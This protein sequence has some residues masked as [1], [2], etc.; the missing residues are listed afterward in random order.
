MMSQEHDSSRLMLVVL[1][2]AFGL[3]LLLLGAYPLMD[4]TEARYA[5]IARKMLELNDWITPWFDYDV[6]FWGKPPLSFWVTATSFKLLGINEFAARFPLYLCGALV[7]WIVWRWTS[8]HVSRRQAGFTSILLAGSLLYFL[9]SGLVMTDMWLLLG[10]TLSMFGFWSSVQ[11]IQ[12]GNGHQKWLFF[13]GLAIGLLSK[14]PIALVLTGMPVAGW[15]IVNGKYRASWQSLPWIRGS[16][17][18]MA[19]CLPWYILAE[20]K[21]PGFAEYFIIGEHVKRFV[22]PGWRGDLYGT[23]HDRPTGSIWLMLLVDGLPWSLILPA[24]F[25]YLGRKGERVKPGPG[26]K[27]WRSYLALWGLMPAVFFTFAGNILWT[28]L[29]PGFPALA[30]WASHWLN[31]QSGV[32][33]SAKVKLL[34]GGT[35]ATVALTLTAVIVLVLGG[36]GEVDSAKSLVELYEQQRVDDEPLLYFGERRFSFDFYSR[37]KAKKIDERSE[38]EARVAAASVF[39]AIESDKLVAVTGA[40]SKVL[41]PVATRGG[42]T[43]L[44]AS[45][46]GVGL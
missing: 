29:L 26:S 8:D 2:A 34:V 31:R 28:Y 42:Y 30:L 41:T 37:G 11:N 45:P 35:V 22:V 4:T 44:H 46:S 6:P 5:E 36:Q 18:T 20:I 3:R 38:L 43:L 13:V 40:A 39:V 17:L 21:T 23:A 1:L 10:T 24:L 27:E 9:S 15:I 12:T 25:F 33:E 32:S 16:L 14:G 7:S 19:L